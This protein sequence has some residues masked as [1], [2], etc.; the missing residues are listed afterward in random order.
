MGTNEHEWDEHEQHAPEGGPDHDAHRATSQSQSHGESQGQGQDNLVAFQD[1]IPELVNPEWRGS[2]KSR[3]RRRTARPLSGS[4]QELQVWLQ[5]G[6]W[7]YVA[8]V[9]VLFVVAFALM[10][11]FGQ[12]S[13]N[14]A[15]SGPT[16]PVPSD[17]R[18]GSSSGSGGPAAPGTTMALP[19][20]TPVPSPSPT[21]PNQAYV[22]ANTGSQ[23]LFLRADH[24]SN[25]AILVT[26]PEGTRV[27]QIGDDFI[28]PNFVWRNVRA[29]GGQEGW[30]AVDWLQEAP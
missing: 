9:A 7:K 5:Q 23:G 30:V 25:A 3:R 20:V 29:P 14:Q 24:N 16:T 18:G 13:E 2:R 17:Q 15:L 27:V 12:K 4:P 19:T 1:D 10:L 11:T 22:V 26:L 21:V 6:G 28:G 8:G